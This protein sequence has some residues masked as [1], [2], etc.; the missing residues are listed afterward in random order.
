MPRPS[1]RVPTA[2]SRPPNGAPT[3]ARPP[4]RAVL[5]RAH[6]RVPDPRA[7]RGRA[8]RRARRGRRAE[9]A[10]AP[11]APA[12]EREPRRL[13]RPDPRRDLGRR[14]APD[15]RDVTPE[16]RLRAAE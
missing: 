8:R 3:G 13:Y 4:P 16:L 11:R 10:R 12:P 2:P 14:A 1:G 15:S 6:G 9:A 5:E 7:A